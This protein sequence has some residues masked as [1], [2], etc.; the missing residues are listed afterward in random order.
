MELR[1][2]TDKDPLI[3]LVLT[4]KTGGHHNAK[5][6]LFREGRDN[7]D[8]LTGTGKQFNRIVQSTYEQDKEAN[9]TPGFDLFNQEP[10]QQSPGMANTGWEYMGAN[11]YDKVLAHAKKVAS[12]I[13]IPLL[14][15]KSLMNTIEVNADD[16]Y[17][18]LIKKL[19]PN[20]TPPG[21]EIKLPEESKVD[22]SADTPP[23][24][25]ISLPEPAKPHK[26][27]DPSDL[28]PGAEI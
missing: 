5:I 10:L 17:A 1:P 24:A 8:F 14:F 20:D 13:G 12:K 16:S 18:N 3:K 28:P 15:G 11:D 4:D 27:S 21:A 9:G 6:R 25:D 22:Y 7:E 26:A 2:E 23:G 19:E